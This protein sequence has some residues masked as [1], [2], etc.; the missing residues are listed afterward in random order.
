M[1]QREKFLAEMEAFAPWL[2]LLVLIEPYFL[3]M[4]SKDGR[5]IMP[6]GVMLRIYCLQQWYALSHPMA[7]E[8]LYNSDATHCF[9]GQELA[10]GRIRKDTTILNFRYLL[11]RHGLPESIFAKVN[12]HLAENDIALRSGTLVETTIIDA[13]SSTKNK[14]GTRD[15]EMTSTKKGNYRYFGMKADVDV[16]AN[17]GIVQSLKTSPAKMQDSWVLDEFLHG[18]RHPFGRTRLMSAQSARTP[19]FVRASSGVSCAR[20][21]RVKTFI[22][23]TSRSN[24]DRQSQVEGRASLPSAE[25]SVQLH[26]DAV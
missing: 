8:S 21:A 24:T 3:K 14:A 10:D 11:E 2:R 26:Q 6:L 18:Q 23:S 7:E 17:S 19:S 25:A 13:P 16:D 5:P 20:P 4:G 12:A 9:T 1:T 22:P 15:P